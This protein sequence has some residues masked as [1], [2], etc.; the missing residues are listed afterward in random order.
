MIRYPHL[1]VPKDESPNDVLLVEDYVRG[2]TA[3]R[4]LDYLSDCH[5]H[6][7]LARHADSFIKSGNFSATYPTDRVS[8]WDNVLEPNHYIASSTTVSVMAGSC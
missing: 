5:E 8:L 1:F 6:V 3:L 2:C 7:N 4:F